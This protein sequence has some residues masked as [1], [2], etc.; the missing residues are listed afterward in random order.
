MTVLTTIFV[1]STCLPSRLLVLCLQMVTRLF[2]ARNII[3]AAGISDR[4]RAWSATNFGRF[5]TH[6]LFPFH[7]AKLDWHIDCNWP[8]WL[9]SKVVWDVTLCR[10]VCSF[11]R[12]ECDCAAHCVVPD[13]S[14]NRVLV[15]FSVKHAR[16]FAASFSDNE[17]WT[18]RLYF[19]SNQ[20]ARH[21]DLYLYVR[22]FPGTAPSHVMFI[23]LA[24]LYLS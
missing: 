3:A 11:R 10:L 17:T 9:S 8:V 22:K 13:V 2:F 19:M 16:N 24:E 14:K 4:I 6:V 5:R 21:L 23:N 12:F 15:I 18:E 7:L 1:L 20:I